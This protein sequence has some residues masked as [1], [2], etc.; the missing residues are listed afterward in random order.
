MEL[1][2]LLERFNRGETIGE[3][4]EVLL[5]MREQIRSNRQYLFEIN[6]QWHEPDE[7]SELSQEQ[8]Q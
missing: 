3:D 8:Q 4:A 2:E 5:A 6:S 1:K 7:V